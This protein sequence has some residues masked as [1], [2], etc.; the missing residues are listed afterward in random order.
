M[1]I[2]ND[3]VKEC[4]IKILDEESWSVDDASAITGV[5]RP[6]LYRIIE[7]KQQFVQRSIIRKIAEAT[8]RKFIITGD[9]VEFVKV[10][11]ASS[12]GALTD[13]ELEVVDILR[14][15]GSEQR[16]AAIELLRATWRIMGGKPKLSNSGEN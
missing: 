7:G 9:R 16:T 10:A 14:G 5:S 11:A 6:T 8:D 3:S 4:L 13:E 2:T 12:P 1:K 15:L